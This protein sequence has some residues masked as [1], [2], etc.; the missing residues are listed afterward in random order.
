MIVYLL[1]ELLQYKYHDNRTYRLLNK[2][3]GT[4]ITR[5]DANEAKVEFSGFIIISYETKSDFEKELQEL[6]DKYAIWYRHYP[7]TMGDMNHKKNKYQDNPLMTVAVL[8]ALFGVGA[9][10]YTNWGTEMTRS[11]L[12][13]V[14]VFWCVSLGYM[15]RD[16]VD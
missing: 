14:M 8:I 4:I 6:F 9:L 7:L 12:A 1:A 5:I 15:I 13:V 2:N 11:M 16:G 3:M 10:A